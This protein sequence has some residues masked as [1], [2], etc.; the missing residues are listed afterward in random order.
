MNACDSVDMS[1]TEFRRFLQENGYSGDVLWI[2][3][4]DVLLTGS[5][6]VYVKLPVSKENERNVRR[7]IEIANTSHVGIVM[8][9][10]CQLGSVSCCYVWSPNTAL[11]AE[12]HMLPRGTKMS[13]RSG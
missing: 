4:D 6:L 9:V 7:K 3:P 8:A 13:A 10:L 11:E 2:T 1:I 5:K 12:Q